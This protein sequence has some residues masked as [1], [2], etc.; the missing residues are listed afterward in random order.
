MPNP[1]PKPSRILVVRPRGV[2]DTVLAVPA[3]RNLRAAFPEARIDVLVRP[4]AGDVLS[5][6]PYQDEL[7]YWERSARTIAKPGVHTGLIRTARWLRRRR[8]DRA[9]HLRQASSTA[10]LLFLAGIPHRVGFG[11]E[12]GRFLMHRSARPSG[13]RHEVERVLDVLRADNV[14]IIDTHNEGWTDPET[15]RIVARNLPPGNRPRVLLCA[16]SNSPLR[17]WRTDRFAVLVD[18]LMREYSADVFVCDSPAN[19]RYYDAIRSALP[20]TS[21]AHWHDWSSSLTLRGSLS[22]ISRM[23]LAVGVDTGLL[24]LAAAF[25]V[26]VVSLTL[27]VFANRFHPWDTAYRQVLPGAGVDQSDLDRIDLAAV[28]AAVESMASLLAAS[29]SFV[30]S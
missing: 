17:N 13:N 28:K 26:P 24:H 4:Q 29:S 2:G 22:L 30:R 15:D 20:P 18:W 14:P 16:R 9:Y 10:L 19:A 6:C 21:A 11:S 1:D 8:Y 12:F 23:N 5:R 3:L 7:I 27:P 25:H